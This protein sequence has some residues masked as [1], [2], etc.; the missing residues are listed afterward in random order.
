MWSIS[1]SLAVTES[2]ESQKIVTDKPSPG[3]NDGE[4]DAVDSRDEEAL[5]TTEAPSEATTQAEDEILPE[6]S[7]VEEAK[8][9]SSILVENSANIEDVVKVATA[10]T[11]DEEISGNI[12]EPSHEA[13]NTIDD[14]KDNTYDDTDYYY[15]DDYY[16]D[17]DETSNFIEAPLTEVL[18]PNDKIGLEEVVD[19]EPQ[20][21][22]LTSPDAA[23]EDVRAVRQTDITQLRRRNRGKERKARQFNNQQPQQQ[24]PQQQQQQQFAQQQ[25]AFVQR[26]QQ[27]VQQQQQA[28]L[29]Q[30]QPQ[31]QFSQ[32]Q[33]FFQPQQQQQASSQSFTQLPPQSSPISQRFQSPGFINR[34]QQQQQPINNF[35]QAPQ[36]NNQQQQQPQQFT[37]QQLAQ[38]ALQQQLLQQSQQQPQQQSAQ[39]QF[40]AQNSALP[41]QSRFVS[42]G[43][44]QNQVQ[45]TTPRTSNAFQTQFQATAQPFT[46]TSKP[47]I[48][49]SAGFQGTPQPQ[50]QTFPAT[51]GSF[52]SFQSNSNQNGVKIRPAGQPGAQQG[53]SIQ[54]LGGFQGFDFDGSNS[55]AGQQPVQQTFQQFSPTTPAAPVTP[56]RPTNIRPPPN[57]D[58]RQKAQVSSL[59]APSSS[60]PVSNFAQ[61]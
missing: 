2:F 24:Q 11:D 16:Y 47:L 10:T 51:P 15:D 22:D 59:K 3:A 23:E 57:A 56:R 20:D 19:I 27:L 26:Q 32:Q 35:A 60:G 29:A 13:I 50:F 31:Q 1:S 49:G 7:M 39:Q 36:F 5:A 18:Q 42:F 30:Q 12:K 25:Q 58:P 38:F 52:Q 55:V 14:T 21:F 33:Q 61:V 46:T 53:F 44:N 28:F 8:N 43:Q 9:I 45:F 6:E 40:A 37:Q 48:P 34:Q 54:D 4:Q 41:Q 17:E